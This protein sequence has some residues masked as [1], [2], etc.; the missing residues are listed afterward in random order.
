MAV[1]EK[2][3]AWARVRRGGV[4]LELGCGEAKRDPDAVGIDRRDLPGVDLVGDVFDVLG[5]VPTGAAA[6]VASSHF[7]EHV[8]DLERLMAE[9]ARVLRPGGRLEVVVPHF[10]NPYFYSD[11]T[12]HRFF[13]LYTFSYWAEDRLHRRRVPHY[14]P[15][16]SFDLER[17]DLV[18]KAPRPFYLRWAFCRLF[19]LVFN[20]APAFREFYEGTLTGLVPCYEI[21]YRLVRREGA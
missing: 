7:F 6:S 12:H 20:A 8:P 2:N 10:S 4:A 3:G 13:G 1:L 9:L 17:V 21:R 14:T 18:F 5:E 16:V 19:G 15:R 11:P